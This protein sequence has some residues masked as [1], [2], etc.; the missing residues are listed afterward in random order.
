MTEALGTFFLVLALV[1][2]V[3]ALAVRRVLSSVIVLG[4]F[5]FFC[6]AYYALVGALDVSFTEAVVGSGISTVYFTA[7]VF[8]AAREVE[9]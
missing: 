2:A 5:S 7:A 8:W 9:G 3:G 4:A 1:S 6:S